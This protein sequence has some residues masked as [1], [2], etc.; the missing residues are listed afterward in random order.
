MAAPLF[1][2][3]T[4]EDNHEHH[5]E[6]HH[7]FRSGLGHCA[8][9]EHHG[10]DHHGSRQDGY[11]AA[12]C[13]DGEVKKVDLEAGKVTIKHGP[14]KHMDMPGMTMVFTAKDKALLTNVKPGDKV[15]FMVTNEGG[16]MVVTSIT[17]TP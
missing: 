17:A 1:S 6:N 2:T 5:P 16:K 8:T 13:V 7:R 14:I 12:R 4:H 15:Q 3:P 11:V 9:F 10:A